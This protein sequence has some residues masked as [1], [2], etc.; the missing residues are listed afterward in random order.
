MD[1]GGRGGAPSSEALGKRRDFTDPA[2]GSGLFFASVLESAFV[3]AL[4]SAGFFA[5]ASFLPGEPFF[6]AA[7]GVSATGSG[8]MSAALGSLPRRGQEKSSARPTGAATGSPRL[9][10]SVATGSDAI[11][12]GRAPAPRRSPPSLPPPA[13]SGTTGPIGGRG[14][15]GFGAVISGPGNATGVTWLVRARRRSRST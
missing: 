5:L 11:G 12:A 15:P 8:A 2:S 13:A 7:L 9:K 14:P 4:A 1:A 10:T 6:A 3:P